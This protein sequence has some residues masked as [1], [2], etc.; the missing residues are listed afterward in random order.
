MLLAVIA[1][2]AVG[3]VIALVAFNN[4]DNGDNASATVS[5]TTS[6]TTTAPT[7]TAPT[8]TTTSTTGPTGP[9]P[10]QA[11]A[12]FDACLELWNQ[13]NNRAAQTFMANIASNQAVRINV[14]TTAEVPPKCLVRVIANNGDVYTFAEGGGATFPYA[15]S[16]GRGKLEDLSASQRRQNALEQ[17]DGTLKPKS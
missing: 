16:P 1:A 12:D 7:A 3:F 2:A 9:A 11:V 13:P 10:T 4:D 17:P 6:S 14:G 5:Q 8:S 15:P